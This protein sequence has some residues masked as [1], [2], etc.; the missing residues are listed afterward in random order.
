[1]A[2]VGVW[3]NIVFFSNPYLVSNHLTWNVSLWFVK[4]GR[5]CAVNMP[6][7]D[8][9]SSPNRARRVGAGEID[10]YAPP[11]PHDRREDDE[12]ADDD[13]ADALHGDG[14]PAAVGRDNDEG[15]GSDDDDSED[16]V[17]ANTILPS[18]LICPICQEPP[19]DARMLCFPRTDPTATALLQVFE[20]AEIY[21]WIARETFGSKWDVGHPT[22]PRE[23]CPRFFAVRYLTK[24]S[25]PDLLRIAEERIRLGLPLEKKQPSNE[26]KKMFAKTMDLGRQR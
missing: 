13:E 26:T 17:G 20:F 15:M 9:P 3:H 21:K 7:S 11:V 16:D 5:Y 14:P 12:S 6:D 19:T 18:R 8:G 1:M 22:E 25:A 2:V 23:K 24:P 10:R 4:V